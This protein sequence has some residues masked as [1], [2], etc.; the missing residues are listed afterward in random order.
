M[1]VQH[2]DRLKLNLDASTVRETVGGDLL[3]DGVAAH[4]GTYTY[5]D[6]K[7][8]P[9]V[10]FVPRTTLFDQ[11]SLESAAGADVTIQHPPGLVTE[12]NYRD[13]THGA[14]VKAWDAGDG[15]MGVRVRLKTAESK[16]MIRDAIA[17]ATP[18]ELS[19]AYEVDVVDEPGRTEHGHHDAVQRDRSYNALALLTADQ[20]RGGPGMRLQLDGPECAPTGSRIQVSRGRRLDRAAR[21]PLHSTPTGPTTM[22]HPTISNGGRRRKISADTLASIRKHAVPKK[23]A[24]NADQI[25]VGR[26]LVEIEGEEPVDLML[27][28]AM[29]EMLLE[30][31]GAG[32]A[33]AP[34]AEEPMAE[35]VALEAADAGDEDEKLDAKTVRKMIAD[36]LGSRDRKLHADAARRAS[37]NADAA[38]ILPAGYDY[39]VHWTQVALDAI[40]K[41][42]PAL[43]SQAK[44]LA[45]KVVSGDS[46]A[47]GMLRQMLADRRK[48]PE[49][50]SG[51]LAKPKTDSDT[52]EAPWASPTIPELKQ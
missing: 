9:F 36:A 18:V 2:Y 19:P 46:V 44:A 33:A 14:W 29:I 23:D 21:V 48:T 47:E 26:V 38:T 43:E 39:S 17:N 42:S 5:H 28:V 16:K 41:V 37:V 30:G 25:A 34:P 49:P 24:A 45:T 8:A 31:I 4:V 40:A 20:A 6:D 10:E 22:K 52:Q 32:P 35:E 13:V 50:V 11:R 3:V 7:G 27:P 51:G 12:D 1:R 15:N